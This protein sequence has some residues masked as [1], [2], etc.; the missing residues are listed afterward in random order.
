MTRPPDRI[1]A[2]DLGTNSFRMLVAEARPGRSAFR[3]LARGKEMVRLGSG[4][5]AMRRLAP[6]AMARGLASLRRFRQIAGR[7]GAVTR[8]VAT[9]AVREASNRGEF[10]RRAEAEAGMRIEVASG[11]EEARLI[12][13]GVLSALPA[14]RRRRTLLVDIG[15]GSTEFLLGTAGRVDYANSLRMG[16]AR[17]TGRFFRGGGLRARDVAACRAHVRGMLAPVARALRG[18]RFDLAVGTAGTV[19]CMAR[20]ALAFRGKRPSADLNGFAFTAR[21]LRRAVATL[22]SAR[23]LRARARLPGVGTARADIAP[24]GALILEG[25]VEALGIASMTFSEGALREG[26]VAGWLETRRGGADPTARARRESVGALAARADCETS[27]TRQVARLAL[28]LFDQ[29]RR[30]HC[31]GVADR[32]LL[33]AAATLHDVGLFVSHVQHHRHA[34]YLIRNADLLGY[35]E[36]EKEILANVARYHRKSHPKERHE[37]YAGLPRGGRERVRRLAAILRI[38]D[39][40]DRSHASR[41]ADLLCA[42]AGKILRIRLIPACRGDALELERWGA[43]LK[44]GLFEEVFRKK[45][46]FSMPRGQ[47]PGIRSQRTG[48]AVPTVFS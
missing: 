41:V 37:G 3:V 2:I 34:Y 46:R 28:R 44:K 22:L 43:G 36:E 21:E 39:G 17:L 11:D 30:L 16:A 7:H 18:R 5:P 25:A 40:L 14:A 19:Q 42:S 13:A 35:T 15:G 29:T 12:Y 33:W 4:D 20:M 45:V 6:D 26:I 10:L 31:L 8:A 48:S 27:H 38:A 9:S 47:G 23:T 32:E 24:A 1:A